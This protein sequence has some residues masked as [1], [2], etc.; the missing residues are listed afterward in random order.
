MSKPLKPRPRWEKISAPGKK[1]V[2]AWLDW[3]R[4][5]YDQVT[6]YIRFRRSK[7][8]WSCVIDRN[9]VEVIAHGVED[10]LTKSEGA[11]ERY[12]RLVKFILLEY[13]KEG[14]SCLTKKQS[15]KA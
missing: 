15:S 14:E 13:E 9:G 10:T 3:D 5:F 2:Y 7:W 8:E 12:M 6:A 4:A 1:A 11:C